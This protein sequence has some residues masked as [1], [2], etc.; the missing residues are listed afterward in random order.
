[1]SDHNPAS[2]RLEGAQQQA[3]ENRGQGPPPP[4]GLP[5]RV[6]A[7]AGTGSAQ[8]IGSNVRAVVTVVTL[9]GVNSGTDGVLVLSGCELLNGEEGIQQ[10]GAALK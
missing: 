10:N 3:R 4:A 7:E 6:Q 1:M 8:Q 5:Q 2:R 9:A